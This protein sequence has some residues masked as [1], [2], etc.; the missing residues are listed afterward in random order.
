MKEFLYLIDHLM[1]YQV[2]VDQNEVRIKT[3]GADPRAKAHFQKAVDQYVDQCENSEDIK[4]RLS[5]IEF[6]SITQFQTQFS[7]VEIG[8]DNG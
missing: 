4:K 8:M 3:L 7:Q 5:A 6:S 2:I 1:H